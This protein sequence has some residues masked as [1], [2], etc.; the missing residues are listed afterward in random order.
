[1]PS[2]AL[3]T[4]IIRPER[5]RKA[6]LYWFALLD[7]LP[8]RDHDD[9][10]DEGRERNEPERQAIEPE[11]VV[12]VKVGNPRHVLDELHFSR[13]KLKPR[14]QR[15]R[16]EQS[17]QGTQQCHPTHETCLLLAREKQQKTPKCDRHP[18]GET[19]PS[20]FYSSPT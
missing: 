16:Y 13:S 18:D 2:S 11:V 20:H 14:V 1:M 4:P 8:P 6:A 12:Q 5:I 15:N 10:G 19:Q 9:Q 3:K 17:Q 7:R